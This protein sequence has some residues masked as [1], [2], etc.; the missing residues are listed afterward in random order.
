MLATPIA[1]TSLT[2]EGITAVVDSG[3]YRAVR[4]DSSTGL[5]RLETERI[6]YLESNESEVWAQA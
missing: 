3:L 1:E 4:F 2:I 6:S 5:G